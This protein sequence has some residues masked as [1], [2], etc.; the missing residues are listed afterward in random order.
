MER[1]LSAAHYRAFPAYFGPELLG[2]LAPGGSAGIKA[3]RNFWYPTDPIGGPVIDCLPEDVQ[4]QVDVNYLDPAEC[5]YVY[6]QAPP[7][8]QGHSGYW[9]DSRVWGVIDRVAAGLASG[10]GTRASVSSPELIPELG[11]RPQGP[12]PGRTAARWPSRSE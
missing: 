10:N 5:Y 12:R 11:R 4:E 9:A 1:P 6:A 3:W 2:P 8:V 7:A